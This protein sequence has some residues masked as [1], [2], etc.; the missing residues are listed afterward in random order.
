M[1]GIEAMRYGLP[2]VAF[3][4]G[5]IQEWLIDGRN[6]FLVPWMDRTTYAGRVEALLGNKTLARQMG[7]IGRQL[8][9]EH[10]DFSKYI[11]GLEDL[12]AR[13]VAETPG[14]VNA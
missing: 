5:G 13:V 3:D 4:A 11:T 2:V 10:Y 6:G 1:V 14:R 8:V 9:S 7:E 12:F